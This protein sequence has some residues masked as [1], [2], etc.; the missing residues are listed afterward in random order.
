[1]YAYSLPVVLCFA[2]AFVYNTSYDGWLCGRDETG[3]FGVC[4]CVHRGIA[5]QMVA[6]VVKKRT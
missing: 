3:A 4:A 6:A 2:F 5:L 1:V